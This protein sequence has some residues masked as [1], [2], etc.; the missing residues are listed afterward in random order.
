MGRN[1]LERGY[2][3]DTGFE[4]Q[5]CPESLRSGTCVWTDVSEKKSSRTD[6]EMGWGGGPLATALWILL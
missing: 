1:L 5:T 4:V 3:T 2:S 6:D